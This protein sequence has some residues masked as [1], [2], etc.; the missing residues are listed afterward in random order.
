[1]DSEDKKRIVKIILAIAVI[2]AITVIGTLILND[3]AFKHT[4]GLVY[5]TRTGDCYHTIGCGYLRSQIPM[6]IEQA[7]ASTLRVCSRCGG[8]PKGT[9][10]VNNYAAAACI[11]IFI[12][13]AVT[14]IGFVIYNKTHPEPTVVSG[15]ASNNGITG[16]KPINQIESERDRM[17]RN[18]K[19]QPEESIQWLKGKVLKHKRFGEGT[20]TEINNDYIYVYFE[21]LDEVKQFQYPQAIIDKF[22]EI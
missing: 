18:C 8:V 21:E 20:V 17:I 12:E 6:G 10:E 3:I 15:L 2:I 4:E 1:M 19:A 22:L 5:R 11:V 9:I 13:V 14:I 16:T 7:K